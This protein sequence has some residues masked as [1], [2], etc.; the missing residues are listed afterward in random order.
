MNGLALA[1]RY[2]WSRP[3][4]AALN[5]LLLTLG[6]ASV[7]FVLIAKDQIDRAFERDLQG[8]KVVHFQRKE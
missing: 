8:I 7:A 1:W 2:L 3:L 4:T 5:L 6:L